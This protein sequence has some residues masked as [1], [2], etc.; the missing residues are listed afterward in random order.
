MGFL[1]CTR[2]PKAKELGSDVRDNNSAVRGTHK[3]NKE[4]SKYAAP[5]EEEHTQSLTQDHSGNGDFNGSAYAE[6]VPPRHGQGIQQASHASNNSSPQPVTASQ[7]WSLQH[8]DLAATAQP[9]A[10]VQ[11]MAHAHPVHDSVIGHGPHATE[12]ASPTKSMRRSDAQPN[13]VQ[14]QQLALEEELL[15]LKQKQQQQQKVAAA[16]QKAVISDVTP[17]SK[18]TAAVKAPLQPQ[19]S[20]DEDDSPMMRQG[21]MSDLSDPGEYEKYGESGSETNAQDQVNDD[22]IDAQIIEEDEEPGVDHEVA[23]ALFHPTGAVASGGAGMPLAAVVAAAAAYKSQQ[24]FPT[25]QAAAAAQASPTAPSAVAAAA[26]TAA[27]LNP[28]FGS[29][30]SIT[31]DSL[32]RHASSEART[33]ANMTNIN[34]SAKPSS[35]DISTYDAEPASNSKQTAAFVSSPAASASAQQHAEAEEAASHRSDSHWESEEGS[36]EPSPKAEA[37]AT[38]AHPYTKST[39]AFSTDPNLAAEATAAATTTASTAMG[40][41]AAAAAA[42][43]PEPSV[44]QAVD[45]A[46]APPAKQASL[47]RQNSSNS[48]GGS[49]TSTPSKTQGTRHHSTDHA[50]PPAPAPASPAPKAASS[51]HSSAESNVPSYMR[52]TASLEA[53]LRGQQDKRRSSED[54]EKPTSTKSASSAESHVQKTPAGKPGFSTS[55]RPSPTAG[56]TSIA[57]TQNGHHASTPNRPSTAAGAGAKPLPKTPAPPGRAAATTAHPTPS[58]AARK[59]P[60]ASPAPAR[61]TPAPSSDLKRSTSG[62]SNKSAGKAVGSSAAEAV[63]AATAV[64][65]AAT[66]PTAA[67]ASVSDREAAPVPAE[68]QAHVADAPAPPEAASAETPSTT[69]THDAPAPAQAS[70]PAPVLAKAEAPARAASPTPAPAQTEAPARAASP[71]PARAASPTPAPAQTEA[72]ARAASPAPVRAASPASSSSSGLPFG[73]WR[74]VR[75]KRPMT[76]DACNGTVAQETVDGLHEVFKC[77]VTLQPGGLAAVVAHEVESAPGVTAP[78][79]WVFCPDPLCLD[80]KPTGSSLPAWPKKF[81]LEGGAKITRSEY[82]TLLELGMDILIPTK[83]AAAPAAA[84]AAQ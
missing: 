24:I 64:A 5:E 14:A 6:D 19:A 80:S 71:A 59:P 20:E 18:A 66:A 52:G 72:P 31:H 83:Q 27:A 4:G 42:S 78:R 58:S 63:A 56:R 39:S 60:V 34:S 46:P 76:C 29:A 33:S 45:S 17:V 73:Q 75:L 8:Q 55:T 26:A 23:K 82:N 32:D 12:L 50:A 16:Q 25:G 77:D 44:A 28:I 79:T 36:V 3:K 48:K 10:L 69:A 67:A 35:P 49:V 62:S 81:P 74:L 61:S 54:G 65:A 37:T 15:K 13:P 30:A 43:E 41:A 47:P 57:A 51:R 7:P 1:C 53:R 68:P 2:P 84:A 70:T 11:A 40:T 21:S 22:D 9:H 38:A